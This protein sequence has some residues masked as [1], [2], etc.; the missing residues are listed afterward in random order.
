MNTNHSVQASALNDSP[1]G[2]RSYKFN[3]A[4]DGRGHIVSGLWE[5]NGRFYL[6]ISLPGKGCRRIPLRDENN[7]GVKTVSEAVAAAAELRKKTRNGDLPVS[8]RAPE[9][10]EYVKHYI[11]SLK[12]TEAKKLKTINHEDS[13]LKGW[14]EFLKKLRLNQI[15]LRHVS[16]Y[17][18]ERK[19][20]NIG[21][22][23][24]NLDVLTL[25][26]CLK[27]ARR[28]GRISGILPTEGWERLPYKAPKRTLVTKDQIEKICT[29]ALACDAQGKPKYR[30]GELLADV[31]RFLRCSGARIT[32]ALATRWSDVDWDLKQVSLRNTKFDNKIVVDFNPELEAHLRDMHLRRIP[33]V[34]YLFPGTRTDGSVGSVRKTLELVRQGAGLPN[35]G[36]HD[37]RRAFISYCIMSGVDILTVAKWV[38]PI[39][40][41]CL[42]HIGRKLVVTNVKDFDLLELWDD[43]AV[44]VIMN[45]GEPVMPH[46]SAKASDFDRH[47]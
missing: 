29:T 18:T 6:Q 39:E 20:A 24:V 44:Q 36:F 21:N 9:F 11:S 4:K 26:N 17:V 31:L 33:D 46:T 43:R 32:S 5:R 2:A 30:N 1:S 35:F 12:A 23:T 40:N 38:T 3:P 10:D 7:Q 22:R 19:K 25:N 13:I 14:A 15:T 42:K 37:C 28:E 34:D 27:F 45:S 47:L 16:A 41:W 8:H